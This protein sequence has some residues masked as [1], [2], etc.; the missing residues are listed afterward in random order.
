M[1]GH[2]WAG[3]GAVGPAGQGAGGAGVQVQYSTVQYSTV[4]CAVQ[5]STV[6]C[7]GCWGE[8]TGPGSRSTPAAAC[9]GN[10]GGNKISRKSC[11]VKW[12]FTQD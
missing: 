1:T 9:T 11:H 10:R 5:Y 8:R 6:Q 3:R 2:L 12:A 4:Q 7:A